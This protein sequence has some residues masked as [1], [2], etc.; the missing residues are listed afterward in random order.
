MWFVYL[1]LCDNGSLYTGIAKDVDKRFQAHQM[2]RG[3]KYTRSH[4]PIKV[5]FQEKYNTRSLAQKRESEIKSWAR[6]Q[7]IANLDLS[8]FI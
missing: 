5:I 4:P 2:G 1:L 6:D 7:K 8:S 3:A